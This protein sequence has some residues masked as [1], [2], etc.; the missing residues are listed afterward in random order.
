MKE[1]IKDRLRRHAGKILLGGTGA[2][3]TL[4]VVALGAG[5]P[6]DGPASSAPQSD[7][8]VQKLE[9]NLGDARARLAAQHTALLGTPIGPPARPATLWL[10][11]ARNSLPPNR[12]GERSTHCF[13][14][15]PEDPDET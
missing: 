13:S 9:G 11:P 2:L 10:P 5:P 4:S 7:A 3:L 8:V 14:T 15:P 1:E 6:S 12:P